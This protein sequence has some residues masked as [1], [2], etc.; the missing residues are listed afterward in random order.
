MAD[1]RQMFI[2]GSKVELPVW[3]GNPCYAVYW[4]GVCVWKNDEVIVYNFITTWNIPS[5]ALSFTF[6]SVEDIGHDGKI[7]WYDDDNV[8]DYNSANNYPIQFKTASSTKQINVLCDITSIKDN[9]YENMTN[10]KSITI[11]DTIREIGE[12]A[13]YNCTNL[14]SMTIR[15]VENITEIKPYTFHNCT[16]L[17]TITLPFEK[18]TRIGDYAFFNVASTWQRDLSNVEYIGKSAFEYCRTNNLTLGNKLTYIGESAFSG[19]RIQNLIIPNGVKNILAHTCFG[20]SQ[21]ISITFKDDGVE[22]I[23]ESAFEVGG[24]ADRNLISINWGNS[25]KT[26]GKRAFLFRY[27]LKNIIFPNGLETIEDSAFMNCDGLTYVEIPSSIK[28]ISKWAFDN[29]TNLKRIVIHK[30]VDAIPDAPWG[31]G[32]YIGGGKTDCEVEW[33]GEN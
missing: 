7:H 12:Y 8:Y 16:S 29:C 2:N 14:N 26:I 6:P 19:S 32:A 27:G 22:I 25:L 21:I 24:S 10:L 20:C 28:F 31:A 4:N 18:L 3:N 33:V 5:S 11:P 23:G 30:N 1:I 15:G 13:F 9:C 17:Q